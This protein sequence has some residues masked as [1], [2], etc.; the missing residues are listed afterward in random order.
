MCTLTQVGIR[1]TVFEQD[2]SLDQRSRD[3]DFGI[4]W[5]QTPL[6]ECLLDDVRDKI[7]TA[8]VDNIQPSADDFLPVYNGLTSEIIHTIPTPHYI[9]LRRREFARVLGNE[10][11]IRVRVMLLASPWVMVSWFMN[12]FLLQ[13]ITMY[14]DFFFFLHP[15]QQYGKRIAHIDTT[16]GPGV[17]ATF[18][19]GTTHTASILIGADGAHSYVRENLLGPERG[20]LLYSP[21]VLSMTISKLPVEKAKQLLKIHQRTCLLF[22]PNGTFLWIG[23][24]L[25]TFYKL[26]SFF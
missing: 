4:Y 18:E 26:H 3:W 22:H 17:T 6:D 14:T 24:K 19:D 20:E 25:S 9:R 10:I 13:I 23:G 8:Q 1:C 11:D 16:S 5:A 21:V 7:I 15:P 12:R 2:D